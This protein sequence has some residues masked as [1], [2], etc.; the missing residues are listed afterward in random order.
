MLRHMALVKTG[1]S[2]ECMTTIIRVTRIGEAK[3][4]KQLASVA[5]YC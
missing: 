4:A 1:D 5:N 3:T 2:E